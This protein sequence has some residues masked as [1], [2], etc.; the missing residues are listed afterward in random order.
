VLEDVRFTAPV[1]FFFDKPLTLQLEVRCQPDH[2]HLSLWTERTAP[3]G[4][5]QRKQH[6]A[7][8]AP[9]QAPAMPAWRAAPPAY[10]L[11]GAPPK[12]SQQDIYARYF[13]GPSFQVLA[14]DPELSDFAC[15]ARGLLP[16]QSW[17]TDL[18]PKQAHTLPWAREA[19]FQAAGLY[20]MAQRRRM[21]LPAGIQRL[22]LGAEPTADLQQ[23]AITVHPTQVDDTGCTFD[24]LTQKLDGPDNTPHTVVDYMEGYRSIVLHALKPQ[25]QLAVDPAALARRIMPEVYLCSLPLGEVEPLLGS[26]ADGALALLLS[27]KE[28]TH[29][30]TL[31][32]KKRRLEWLAGRLVAKRVISATWML[33]GPVPGPDAI[34]ITADAA[35]APQVEVIGRIL[36][37]Q[38]PL[39][40]VSHGAGRAVAVVSW[41]PSLLPGVDV[42]EVAERVPAFGTTYFTAAEQARAQ[43]D[44]SPSRMLTAMWAV[45]EATG[46]ALGLGTRLDYL[47]V[48][49]L[50]AEGPEAG[51]ALTWRLAATP[52][53]APLLADRSLG[54]AHVVVTFE[55]QTVQAEVVLAAT[56]APG[57]QTKMP[58]H[59]AL[60]APVPPQA[61][62][63]VS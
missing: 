61:E 59:P 63:T 10:H 25:E 4:T 3:S 39:L 1:K 35:G 7:A 56:D 18:H 50:P 30:A 40:S 5:R 36:G 58:F 34:S 23:V 55:D 31:T 51:T 52:K 53:S 9:L 6:F 14:G 2:L 45:K 16:T 29:L 44:A 38:V 22:H 13:H 12:L 49:A 17:L 43:Q 11:M 32:V 62:K 24:I 33:D 57:S 60:H 47:S 54:S 48:E 37:P 8:R 27:P 26:D 19:G 41:Q 28:R 21:A 46:K 42:E 20:E 15:Q